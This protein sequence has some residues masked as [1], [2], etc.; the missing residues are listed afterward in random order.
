MSRRSAQT[1]CRT[2]G[3]ASG[4]LGLHGLLPLGMGDGKYR[5][6]VYR[7]WK[8]RYAPSTISDRPGDRHLWR[9][10]AG[11]PILFAT[12]LDLIHKP[13]RSQDAFVGPTT[14]HHWKPSTLH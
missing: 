6:G 14:T 5:C 3:A 2:L 12:A 1:A 9:F 10:A 11:A 7:D 13:P 8:P 4:G